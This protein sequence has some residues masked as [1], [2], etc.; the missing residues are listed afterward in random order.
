LNT[1]ALALRQQLEEQNLENKGQVLALQGRIQELQ[2]RHI[3][4]KKEE[5]PVKKIKGVLTDVNCIGTEF[6]ELTIDQTKAPIP[7]MEN[8]RNIKKILLQAREDWT[9]PAQS[10]MQLCLDQPQLA[11]KVDSISVQRTNPFDVLE[12]KDGTLFAKT[13]F[14]LSG[15][16]TVEKT[17][18]DVRKTDEIRHHINLYRTPFEVRFNVL[19]IPYAENSL[20]DELQKYT[21]Y[22]NNVCIVVNQHQQFKVALNKSNILLQPQESRNVDLYL[23][24]PLKGPLPSWLEAHTFRTI[25]FKNEASLKHNGKKFEAMVGPPPY[26]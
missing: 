1:D 12:M 2:S 4:E 23:N 6:C 16:I 9:S 7:E 21:S 25:Y 15:S 18:L 8:P 5:A 22:A 10:L 3:E 13:I 17:T 20:T 11:R 19:I 26:L 14:N 24:L